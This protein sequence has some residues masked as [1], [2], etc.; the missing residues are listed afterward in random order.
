MRYIGGKNGD[1]T[2]QRI[3]NLIP[4]HRVYIEPFLGSGAILR[5]KRPA[6]HS[7][8]ID[9]ALAPNPALVDRQDV[10]LLQQDGIAF[11][12]SYQWSGDEFIYADPPYLLSTRGGRRYYA[13]E[14]EDPGHA[15]LLAA[16][17]KIP[18]KMMISGYDSP[19][20]NAALIGWRRVEFIA[21]TRQH[22]KRTEVLWFNYEPPEVLHDHQHV[23]GDYRD[24]WRIEKRRR[25]WVARMKRLAPLER[26]AL[27]VALV[28]VMAELQEVLPAV[29][30]TAPERALGAG[31]ARIE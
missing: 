15:R 30:R 1:G 18:A 9:L 4:P 17:V 14:L 16:A 2:F 25:R 20:Y 27:Y 26:S 24:R 28:D 8:G 6:A 7:Y 29:D 11:L 31:T 13:H 5:H 19:M 12:E 23:G 21:Y 3:I 22:Q 10:T